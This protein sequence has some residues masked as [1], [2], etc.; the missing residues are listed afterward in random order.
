MGNVVHSISKIIF[1]PAKYEKNYKYV[2]KSFD[3]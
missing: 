1:Q 2:F 3:I